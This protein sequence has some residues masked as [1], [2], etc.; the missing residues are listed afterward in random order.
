MAEQFEITIL[1]NLIHNEEFTRK[2]LPFLK[3]DFFKNRDEI[4]LFNLIRDQERD[5]QK[6]KNPF[7][8]SFSFVYI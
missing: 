1:R 7:F 2:V 4:I 5:H 3:V 8:F 6:L